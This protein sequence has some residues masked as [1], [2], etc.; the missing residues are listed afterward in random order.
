MLAE[1][2]TRNPDLRVIIDYAS[3][4][5]EETEYPAELLVPEDAKQPATILIDCDATVD[6]ALKYIAQGLGAIEA[7]YDSDEEGVSQAAEH[8]FS[9][10]QSALMDH[11]AKH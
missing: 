6:D 9:C 8:Y 1:F 2:N 4:V 5:Q 7:G 3:G 10:A 11:R